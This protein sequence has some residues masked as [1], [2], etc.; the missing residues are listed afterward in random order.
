MASLGQT[1]TLADSHVVVLTLIAGVASADDK[2]K[3]VE[4]ISMKN[5]LPWRDHTRLQT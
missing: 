1:D 4:W 5:V 2:D 3:H